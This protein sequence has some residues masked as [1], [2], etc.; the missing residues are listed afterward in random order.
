ML[1]KQ[2]TAEAAVLLLET[3]PVRASQLNVHLD[4]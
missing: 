3:S 1:L 4:A 2:A